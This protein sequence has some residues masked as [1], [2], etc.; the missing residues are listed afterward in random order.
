MIEDCKT[1]ALGYDYSDAE[2]EKMDAAKD[3]LLK[4]FSK[5]Y[6]AMWW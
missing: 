1:I 6:W 3:D 2:F 4:V 5:V